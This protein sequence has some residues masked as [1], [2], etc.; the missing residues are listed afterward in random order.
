MVQFSFNFPFF[1][2]LHTPHN[3]LHRI[4]VKTI[5]LDGLNMNNSH[6]LLLIVISLSK[7]TIV[8]FRLKSFTVLNTRIT[9][10][11]WENN[12]IFLW[13]MNFIGT[14]LFCCEENT[15]PD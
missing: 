6:F 3:F 9:F 10:Y 8:N 12:E 4:K 5:I 1:K 7:L 14:N 13:Y 2:F 15:I 11:L